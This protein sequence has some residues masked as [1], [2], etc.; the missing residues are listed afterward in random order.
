MKHHQKQNNFKNGKLL[1]PTPNFEDWTNA[2][3][4]KNFENKFKL[5]TWVDND[6]NL[7]ALAESRKGAGRN[8]KTILC[9]TLGTGI[10]GGI[11]INNELF[12]V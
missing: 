11:I 2:P 8:Y 1:G 3:I 5:P 10:G 12:H 6:A 4:K 9:V 7:V